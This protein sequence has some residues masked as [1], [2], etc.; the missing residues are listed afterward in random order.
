MA[1]SKKKD[2]RAG[3]LSL[4]GYV[5]RLRSEQGI[6]LRR[7]AISTGLSATSLCRLEK[8]D[9]VPVI[10]KDIAAI[11]KLWSALGGD[12]NQMLYLSR[13]CPLCSGLGTLK[14]WTE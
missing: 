4:G 7:L 2:R 9:Y 11:D 13:R 10:Q 12:M 6:T 3:P 14:D 1:S 8:G 5:Y